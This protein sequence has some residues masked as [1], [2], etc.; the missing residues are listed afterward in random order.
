MT[1]DAARA[2]RALLWER[3][4][5]E[6]GIERVAEPVA[7]QVDA[8]RREGE[9]RAREGGEPPGDVEEVAALG[10]HAPPRGRRRLDAEAEEADRRLRDDERGELEARD[11][12]DGRRDVGQDVAEQ[13]P[14]PARP[15]RRPG[16]HAAPPL[17]P[18]HLPPHAPPPPHP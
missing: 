4:D 8:E 9:R 17:P 10:E 16:P 1:M 12:D 18:R 6:S 2:D 15:E 7:E 13:D 5:A 11:D 3:S 14:R